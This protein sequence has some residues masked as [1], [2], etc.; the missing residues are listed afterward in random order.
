MQNISDAVKLGLW[1]ES[2]VLTSENGLPELEE[3]GYNLFYIGKN[4][5]LY[6][7]A[8]DVP[9]VLLVRSDRTSVFDIPLDLQIVGKGI[10]QS[11][12]SDLGF[13]FAESMGIKTARKKLPVNLPESVK[14]RSQLFELCKPVYTLHNNETVG[15]EL[16][17][18]KYLTGSLFKIYKQ[19]LDPYELFLPEGMNEWDK[20]QSV[21]FTPT[22]KGEK[23]IP[24]S[25]LRVNIDFFDIVENLLRLFNQF[26]EECLI[27]GIV[28]VDTKFEVFYNSNGNW[29]LGDEVLTPES[30]RYIDLEDFTKND[31]ISM[32]KQIL[33]NYGEQAG[34]KEQAK[35]L[36][37][38]Q[39]LH[40]EVPKEIQDRI[41]KGYIDVYKTLKRLA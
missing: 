35:T 4:A 10:V 32:D 8:G 28:V 27:N 14:E 23:D 25:G 18:R 30:S 36:E 9:H 7:V 5:D 24:M 11:Q 40:V 3:L 1:P 15:M 26:Y 21:I 20:F 38:G 13:D 39:K 2:K 12:I 41:L 29:V 16:I 6:F 34:W 37:K 33:R 19:G 31:Y 22:T 17:F